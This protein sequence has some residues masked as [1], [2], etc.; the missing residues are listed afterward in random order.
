MIEAD[1]Y[2][3]IVGN[4]VLVV[5]QCWGVAGVILVIADGKNWMIN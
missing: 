4:V 5:S 3:M 1:I 2:Q